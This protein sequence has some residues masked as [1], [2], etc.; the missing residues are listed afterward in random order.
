MATPET[1]DGL[2]SRIEDQAPYVDVKPYSH[3]IIGILLSQL[4][5]SFGEAEANKAIRDFG[6]EGKG[7]HQHGATATVVTTDRSKLRSAF[8]LLRRH[9]YTARQ[10]FSCCS[11]CAWY[12]LGEAGKSELCVFYN[13]QSNDAWMLGRRRRQERSD[14]LQQTLFLQ[15]SGDVKLIVETLRST[16]LR[17]TDHDV[18]E[19]KCI[20]VLTKEEVTS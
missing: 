20:E 17:V 15:W 8:K 13:R 12:E 14:T 9:G 19:N 1:L 11:S 18:D 4:A 10:A 16:G 3:N 7:W 5:S 2:R 6:L